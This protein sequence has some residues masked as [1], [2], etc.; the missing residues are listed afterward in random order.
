MHEF[1]PIDT[2]QLS[3]DIPRQ[4]H[5]HTKGLD[6]KPTIISRASCPYM[7]VKSVCDSIRTALREEDIPPIARTHFDH[8][9]RACKAS[10][11]EKDLE[12]YRLW[13][14]EFGSA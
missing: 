11:S 4:S 7:Q 8:A 1:D 13:D 3:F 2:R 14:A 6:K 10:V 5:F 12:Q 9:L